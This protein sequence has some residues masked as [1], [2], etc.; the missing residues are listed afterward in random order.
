MHFW[1]NFPLAHLNEFFLQSAPIGDQIADQVTVVHVAPTD[2][3][4]D[5]YDDDDDDDDA[6]D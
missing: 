4:Y 5:Y 3:D 6:D 2:Y 1:H